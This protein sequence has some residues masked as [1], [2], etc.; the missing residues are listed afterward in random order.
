MLSKSEILALKPPEEVVDVG[1]GKITVR[2][3]TAAEYGEYER[4]LVTQGPDGTVKPKPISATFRAALVARCLSDGNGASFTTEEV[5]GID[6]GVV[7]KL[8]HVARKLCGVS[9]AD[10]KELA[11]VFGPAQDDDASSE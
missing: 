4:G 5:A 8:Y 10:E 6:A 3:L 11:A 1:G 2:G 7:A 9:D